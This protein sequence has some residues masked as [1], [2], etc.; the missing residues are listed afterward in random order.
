MEPGAARQ[1]VRIALDSTYSLDP[2]PTGVA[3]YSRQLLAGLAAAH[4]ETVFLHCARPHRFLRSLRAAL[5][6]NCRRRLLW[7][8]S[9]F[10]GAALFHGLN[11]RLPRARQRRAV[12]T[13]HD[14]FVLS[15]DYSS[16]EFRAR[17]AAQAR[18]AAERA[19]LLVAVSRFTASQLTDLLQVE[20]AR[21]RVVPHGAGIAPRPAAAEAPREKIILHVG[22]I[23]RRKNVARLVEAFE[24]TAPGWRLVLA[25]SAGY[26]AQE[27]LARLAASPRRGDIEWTGYLSAARLADLYRRAGIFAFPS[28]DEGFGMP[29]LEAMAWGV[30][31]ITSHGSALEEVAGEA[32]LLV[33]PRETDSIAAALEALAGDPERRE[34][35]AAAGRA[36]AARFSW[37]AAVGGTW[38]VYQELV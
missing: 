33:E 7:E 2:S 25:G 20:P 13:F 14:L 31:V 29:V 37:D 4:P 1:R 26:G 6:A 27:I 15:G 32:A 24:R 16:P 19:D 35:L 9:R 8:S 21:I 22:A 5:P 12:A 34:R 30:P 23:Q 38:A 11:Q 17:F 18:Q 10:P 3:V 28:L 36:H